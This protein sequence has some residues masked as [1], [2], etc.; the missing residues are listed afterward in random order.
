MV[1]TK[2]TSGSFCEPP[3]IFGIQLQGLPAGATDE[4][5]RHSTG[6]QAHDRFGLGA[7]PATVHP[8]V[9][10]QALQGTFC[11]HLP[12]GFAHLRFHR[13]VQQCG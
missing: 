6:K 1:S 10:D 11:R 8:V 13:L 7:Q 2:T 12:Q 9:Q 5:A 3:I 4:V